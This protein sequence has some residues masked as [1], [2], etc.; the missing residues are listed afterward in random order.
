L[1]M[2]S[3]VTRIGLLEQRIYLEYSQERLAQYGVRVGALEHVL[4]DRNITL[5]GG[6]L[7]AG[8]KNLTIDPSGE[9]HSEREIGDVLAPTS[10]GRPIYLRGLVSIGRGY[11]GPARFLNFFT[12]RTE[13]GSWRRSRA[14]T[15]AVQ[16]RAGQKIG[17]FGRAVDASLAQL[18]AQLPEDLV[19][20]RTS[21]QPRQV[22]ENVGLFMG[23]LYEA[24]VLVVVV[25]LIGFWE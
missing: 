5:P 10:S 23:S 7:E 12:S 3:K 20:A 13:D 16:M 6:I 8:D 4:S 24:I 14:M 21:D 17:E 19:L 22:E 18:R 1:P 15:L 9:F 11:E 25:S 2:V